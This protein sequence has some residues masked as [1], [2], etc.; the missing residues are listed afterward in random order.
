MSKISI[1]RVSI[2]KE[3]GQGNGREGI[4][5]EIIQENFLELKGLSFQ[6]E[7]IQPMSSTIS[8]NRTTEKQIKMTFQ[9]TSDKENS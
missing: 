3:W 9:F 1:V 4:F 6:M 8:E 2:K 5:K 7:S